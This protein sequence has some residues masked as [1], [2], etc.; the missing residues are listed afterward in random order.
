MGL[1]KTKVIMFMNGGK[2][3]SKEKK[4]KFLYK[5]KT[6]DIVTHY[7]GVPEKYYRLTI[8]ETIVFCFIV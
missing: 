7:T 4:E 8:H 3:S 1:A 6:I 5:W 2:V